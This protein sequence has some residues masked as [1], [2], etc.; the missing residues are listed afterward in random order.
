MSNGHYARTQLNSGTLADWGRTSA[1]ASVNQPQ[2]AVADFGGDNDVLG[3][4]QQAE[5]ALEMDRVCQY[6]GGCNFVVGTGDN[7]YECG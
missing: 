1:P 5:T 3:G 4:I 7:F 6:V 2:C